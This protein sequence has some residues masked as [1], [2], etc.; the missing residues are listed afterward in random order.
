MQSLSSSPSISSEI[1]LTVFLLKNFPNISCDKIDTCAPVSHNTLDS[2]SFKKH[3][4]VHRRP[5]SLAI[6]ACPVGVK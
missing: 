1:S 2:T 5:T 6:F 3:L 4:T